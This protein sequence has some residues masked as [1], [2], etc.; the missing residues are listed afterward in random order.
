MISRR[1]DSALSAA[2]ISASPSCRTCVAS[3]ILKR[4]NEVCTSPMWRVAGIQFR[5][6]SEDEL[7]TL[8]NWMIEKIPIAQVMATT[9]TK[10]TNN[11]L[12]ILRFWN[13]CIDVSG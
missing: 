13:Q 4:A 6:I 11:L 2:F 3:E 5:A 8:I 10:A 9:G 1:V 7:P 12:V